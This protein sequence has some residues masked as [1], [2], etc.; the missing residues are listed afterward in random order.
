MHI[1]PHISN[2][3]DSEMINSAYINAIP[4]V[5]RHTSQSS[6][7]SGAHFSTDQCDIVHIN[8]LIYIH[9]QI[10]TTQNLLRLLTMCDQT[11][12]KSDQRVVD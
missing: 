8:D 10:I 5:A 1:E 6:L 4:R 3:F 2:A 7:I 11:A 12:H 9:G